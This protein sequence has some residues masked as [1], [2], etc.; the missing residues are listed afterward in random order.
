M[1]GANYSTNAGD[2]FYS[3][4]ATT[5]Q[6][7]INGAG[8][9]L[10]AGNK[11]FMTLWDGGGNDTYDLSNH[12]GG[13]RIDLNPGGWTTTS[14]GQ[15]ATL[16]VGHI[17]AG[18]VANA[19]LYNGNLASLIENAIGG[20]GAD[21]LTGNVGNN[22][23]TGGA[24]ADTLDGAA[25]NDTA[26]YSGLRSNFSWVQNDDSWTVTDLRVDTPDGIDILKGIEYLQFTDATVTIST[27]STLPVDPPL[28]PDPPVPTNAAPI[29]VNDAYSVAKGKSLTVA[30]LSGLLKNDSDPDGDA[31][32]AILVSG[33]GKGN[34]KFN[35]DGS[36]TFTPSKNFTGTL[37]FSYDASDG[38]H[39][40]DHATV[41]INVGMTT[42]TGTGK[43]GGEESI[44]DDQAPA[45]RTADLHSSQGGTHGDRFWEQHGQD[46][47]ANG[48]S[49]FHDFVL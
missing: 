14:A 17:A 42:T 31:L 28:P 2:S 45:P 39:T 6:M 33:P 36:F 7:S 29:A 23:L 22:K 19:L 13:V 48:L 10:P 24:G 8:Q 16:A 3:W 11:V 46:H 49:A 15:L 43:G 30:A 38:T 41:T 40:S 5:G 12:A 25:G 37:K 26:V 9:W 21:T 47:H 44:E 35:A 4:S 18:N 1:Y 34:L 20:A 32:Q 27:P